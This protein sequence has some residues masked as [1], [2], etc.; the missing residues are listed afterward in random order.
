MVFSLHVSQQKFCV[1]FLSLPCMLHAS[2][3]L[4]YPPLQ[5]F[6]NIGEVYKLR[7]TQMCINTGYDFHSTGL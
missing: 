3:V 7:S 4:S 1:H 6:I 5:Y 2:L